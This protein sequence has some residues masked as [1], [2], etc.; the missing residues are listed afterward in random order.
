MT[1]ISKRSLVI[2]VDG[3]AASGKGTLARKLAAHYG[4]PHLDTGLLYR[5]VGKKLLEARQQGSRDSDKLIAIHAAQNLSVTDLA[6][7]DLGTEGVG[8]AASIISAIPEVRDALL[9]Y[10]F[11]FAD[12]EGGAVLDGRD[13][14]T[15]I[16]PDADVKLFITASA[17]VRAKRRYEQQ[18]QTD[19]SADYQSIL[20]AI[21]ERDE[22]D[23]TRTAAPL[24]VAEDAVSI[25]SSDMSIDAVF[26]AAIEVVERIPA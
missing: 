25:D 10:Q 17:E 4:L 19:A 13:I 24:T 9:Q 22:R 6:R 2:A 20:T 14:G 1:N 5:A 8:R 21:L 16:C 11:D 23:S 7:N 26:A 18:K 15:V 3:P 12:Q